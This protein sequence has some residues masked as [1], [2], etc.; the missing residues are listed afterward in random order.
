[1]AAYYDEEP[2]KLSKVGN[3]SY[4][5]VFN[6]EEKIDI[7]EDGSVYHIWKAEEIVIYPPLSSNSLIK[8]VIEE[9]YGSDKEL[10]LVNEY[11]AAMMGLILSPEKENIIQRYKD[12]LIKRASIKQ[13][14][15]ADCKEL[16]IK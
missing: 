15:E 14:I 7:L 12:F 5:Y 10:K 9:Y 16:G 2:K 4:R 13:M 8:A 3:G 1:M 6:V 11:N